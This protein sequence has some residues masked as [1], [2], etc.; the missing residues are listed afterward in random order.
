MH[1]VDMTKLPAALP[2][3][4]EAGARTHTPL[5]PRLCT[6]RWVISPASNRRPR[7]TFAAA[8]QGTWP[9]WLETPD[10]HRA[11]ARPLAWAAPP[12]M[13]RAGSGLP[14]PLLRSA[15]GGDHQ[16]PRAAHLFCRLQPLASVCLAQS[17]GST[18]LF[19]ALTPMHMPSQRHTRPQLDGRQT[20]T[21]PITTVKRFDAW[22]LLC[23]NVMSSSRRR[24]NLPAGGHDHRFG[25]QL[26]MAVLERRHDHPARCRAPRSCRCAG[27]ADHHRRA[28]H[29]DAAMVSGGLRQLPGAAVPG[30]IS[31]CSGWRTWAT[32]FV[33][34]I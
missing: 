4:V 13:P 27:G 19:L 24:E 9:G 23:L 1:E 29:L 20:S 31:T 16:R 25:P 17:S 26:A 6:S 15:N 30:P 12:F 8:V 28:C 7:F 18:S 34:R 5:R 14:L 11:P 21:R 33:R 22:Q 32:W 3:G 2:A 10:R